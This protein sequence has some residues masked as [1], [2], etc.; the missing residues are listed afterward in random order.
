MGN[1]QPKPKEFIM[2]LIYIAT[3]PSGKSYI[4]QTVYNVTSR[5]RDHIYDA[6]DPKK[7][8]CKLLNR[9]IRKYGGENF[10]LNVICECDDCELNDKETYYIR[11]HNTMKPT[12]YNLKYG[13]SIG[14]HLDET[15][16]KISNKLKGIPKPVAVL[17]KRS[18]TKKGNS[19]LPMYVIEC[20]KKGITIGYR[21]T[22][23]KYSEKRFTSSDL[24]LTEKLEKA[25]SHLTQ[26]KI[27]SMAPVQRLNGD[28]FAKETLPERA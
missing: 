8:H 21:V 5:W 10:A 27:N 23:P 22:H 17:E 16:V 2:G 12:G 26:L 9:A 18:I 19:N 13:G 7:D 3:S 24:S 11:V 20:R 1:Q 15:K 4:G 14:R 28:G 25:I 6:M